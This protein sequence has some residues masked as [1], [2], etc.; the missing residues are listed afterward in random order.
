MSGGYSIS[1]SLRNTSANAVRFVHERGYRSAIFNLGV[2]GGIN[3]AQPV[4][5][6]LT[7]FKLI[8]QLIQGGKPVISFSTAATR[9]PS[10]LWEVHLESP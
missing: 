8:P 1:M 4:G 2:L 3:L 9:Q 6:F 10:T 5:K 7:P